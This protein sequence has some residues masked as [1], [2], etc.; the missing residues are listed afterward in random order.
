MDI[1]PPTPISTQELEAQITTL[2]RG[3]AFAE[4][5]GAPTDM[6]EDI[7]RAIVV[8]SDMLDIAF[9]GEGK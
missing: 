7:E 5:I 4:S 2:I 6:I 1:T 3:K 9:S 8:R